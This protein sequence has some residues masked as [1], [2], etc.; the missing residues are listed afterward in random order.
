MLSENVA[1]QVLS[2]FVAPVVFCFFGAIRDDDL[3]PFEHHD[4]N[5]C[6]RMHLPPQLLPDRL[7][8]SPQAP[9]LGFPLGY[10]TTIRVRAQ[11]CVNPRKANVSH[12][13]SRAALF[14]TTAVS[15]TPLAASSRGGAA[16]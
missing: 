7:E 13:L 9:T 10:E 14:A 2:D 6:R 11:W 8:L 3:T 1:G 12:R 15:P 5:R 4:L 16:G